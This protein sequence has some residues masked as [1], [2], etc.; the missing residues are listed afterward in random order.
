MS[1]VLRPETVDPE[2]ERCD[3]WASEFQHILA[4]A[5]IAFLRKRG[6]WAGKRNPHLVPRN[7][8]TQF[9]EEVA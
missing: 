5:E 9:L 1:C 7:S 3:F 2:R 8:H 6:F 4:R